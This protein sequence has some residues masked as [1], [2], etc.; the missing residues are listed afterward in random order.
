MS[1]LLMYGIKQQKRKGVTLGFETYVAPTGFD[2]TAQ[3]VDIYAV[4]NAYYKTNLEAKWIYSVVNTAT[5]SVLS[6]GSSYR[7]GYTNG[8]V[9]YV[10]DLNT[11]TQLSQAYNSS[12]VTTIN[13]D[14]TSSFPATGSVYIGTGNIFIYT[15]KTATSFSGVGQAIYQA[16]NAIVSLRNYTITWV[17]GSTKRWVIVNTPQQV[18]I[19]CTVVTTENSE[20]LYCGNMISYVFTAYCAKLKWIHIHALSNITQYVSRAHSL[21]PLMEGQLYLSS[22]ATAIQGTDFCWGNAKLTGT[23]T[24]PD[25]FTSLGNYAFSGCTLVTGL[26]L[27]NSLQAIGINA[28]NNCPNLTG[29]LTIPNTVKSIGAN[30]FSGDVKLTSLIFETTSTLTTIGAQAFHMC[31]FTNDLVIPPDVTSIGEAAFANSNFSSIDV[32][33]N[34]SRYHVHDSVLYQESNHLAIYSIKGN[35]NTI[36]FE[37]DTT[38][39]GA[40]CCYDNARTGTLSLPASLTSVGQYAFYSTDFTGTLTIPDSCT[41]I[42]TYAFAYCKFTGLVL[43]TTTSS[44]TSIGPKVFQGTNT[45]KGAL[46]LPDSLLTIGADCFYLGGSAFT[47]FHVGSSITS[48]GDLAYFINFAS[49]TSITGGSTAYPVSDNVLYFGKVA[50]RTANAYAGTLTF[51]SD[52][53]S[54]SCTG[55]TLRTGALVIPNS[56]TA[57]IANAFAGCGFTSISIGTGVTSIPR[58]MCYNCTALTGT[59]TLPSGVTSLGDFAFNNTAFT[60]VDSYCST[61]PSITG[62][63]F[64]NDAMELHIPT[65]GGTGYGVAPWTTAAIFTQPAIADL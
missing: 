62:T 43:E 9:D 36:T 59:L 11:T 56:V 12:N 10:T 52:T 29:S 18:A 37:S 17:A 61:A 65:G 63:P 15:S 23:I 41:T 14:D 54:I 32:S 13:V 53:T 26:V 2:R 1:R 24:I 6:A 39:I 46:V 47:S 42:E 58:Q 4:F 34:S 49:I 55:F 51:K 5:T 25:T 22:S 57:I 33:A 35:A 38:R 48:L 40:Y 50:S 60:R 64:D 45:F 31:S 21:N 28:A 19:G 16:D 20:W 44:L 7:Y 8:G 27:G 3:A 30:A